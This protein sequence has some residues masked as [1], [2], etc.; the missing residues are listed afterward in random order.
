MEMIPQKN[1]TVDQDASIY[2]QSGILGQHQDFTLYYGET[3]R[4]LHS[5]YNI[6]SSA[7]APKVQAEQR[8]A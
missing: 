3:V 8:V 1:S 4:N 6:P 5:C 7:F 2:P